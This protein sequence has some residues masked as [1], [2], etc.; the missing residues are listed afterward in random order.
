MREE[1][2]ATMK[3]LEDMT[4]NAIKESTTQMIAL[5]NHFFLFLIQAAAILVVLGFIALFF[6]EE[7]PY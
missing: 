4:S 7:I 1:R 2:S 6:W 5:M 3:A